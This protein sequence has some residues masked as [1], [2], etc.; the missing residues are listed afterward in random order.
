[1]KIAFSQ[2]TAIMRGKR[3]LHF[4]VADVDIGMMAR[5]FRPLAYCVHETQGPDKISKAEFT[6]DLFARK[7][8]S[9]QFF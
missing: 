9:W 5:G 2:P 7:A 4:V 3:Q 1:M 6:N 8:P